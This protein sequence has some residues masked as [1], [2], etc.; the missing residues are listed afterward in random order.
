MSQEKSQRKAHFD[1]FINNNGGAGYQN[2]SPF[3]ATLHYLFNRNNFGLANEYEEKDYIK[4]KLEMLD[5]AY[6]ANF[7]RF[8]GNKRVELLVDKLVEKENNFEESHNHAINGNLNKNNIQIVIDC[9]KN[10]ENIL[11][12][13]ALEIYNTNLPEDSEKRKNKKRKKM[14][15]L[16]FSS[17]YLFF[18]HKIV[19]IFDSRALKSLRKI[20][21]LQGTVTYEKYVKVFFDFLK[22]C[23]GEN[24]AGYTS[25]QIKDLDYYLYKHDGKF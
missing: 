22:E 6:L 13:A 3:T 15:A 12:Q 10:L 7:L 21:G 19:P 16:S 8:L 25:D 2:R 20:Y 14:G 5:R 11:S 24:E 23:Y 9:V 4:S 18:Q 1:E 17:K